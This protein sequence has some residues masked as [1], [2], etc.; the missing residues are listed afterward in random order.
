MHPIGVIFSLVQV[1][2]SVVVSG[3]LPLVL[4]LYLPL[5]LSWDWSPE[6]PGFQDQKPLFSPQSHWSLCSKC[7]CWL[8]FRSS[9]SQGPESMTGF[10][11]ASSC[12]LSPSLPL[13]FLVPRCPVLRPFCLTLPLFHVRLPPGHGHTHIPPPL[14][15][16]RK[17]LVAIV[18]V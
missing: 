15:L 2:P 18:L 13:P 12:V 14:P 7:L 4:L 10:F 6:A 1:T 3:W 16:F 5:K 9:L 8:L 17:C 11:P